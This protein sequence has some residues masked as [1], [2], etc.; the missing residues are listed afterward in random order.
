MRVEMAFGKTGLSLKLPEAAQQPGAPRWTVLEPRWAA[1]LEDEQA[2][3]SAALDTPSAGPALED[4]A[5]GCGSAA[6]S[7]CD[8][9]RPAP[10]RVTLPPVLERLERA[11]LARENITVLIATG[12]HRP[13]PPEEIVAIVGEDV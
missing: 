5:R 13:A 4:L 3:I 9:T 6:I 12:L 2:A 7:V 10:N 1:Q 8:I 11:G